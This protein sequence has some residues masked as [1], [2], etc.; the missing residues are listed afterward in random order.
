MASTTFR[1]LAVGAGVVACGLVAA[2]VAG[3]YPVGPWKIEGPC[4]GK[5][6]QECG[7]VPSP[8]G[9]TWSDT[10]GMQFTENYDKTGEE[11]CP[12]SPGV[13]TF[14]CD[15]LLFSVRALPPLPI[16]QWT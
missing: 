13:P 9:L 8:D 10:L 2:P 12:T 4:A 7:Y 14:Y 5:A 1:G 3:A 6:P 16:G 11:V 15:G